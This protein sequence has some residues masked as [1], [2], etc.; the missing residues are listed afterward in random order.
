MER[1]AIFDKRQVELSFFVQNNVQEHVY[2]P[3]LKAAKKRIQRTGVSQKI[4]VRLKSGKMRYA[5]AF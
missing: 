2:C 1:E 5:G 4:F 3:T